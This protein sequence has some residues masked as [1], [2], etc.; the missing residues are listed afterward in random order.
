MVE[1][2]PD[3][4]NNAEKQPLSGGPVVTELFEITADVLP[5]FEGL[6]YW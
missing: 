3:A 1:K 5:L 2:K 4:N 6:G